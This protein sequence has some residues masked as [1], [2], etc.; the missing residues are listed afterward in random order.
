ML[1]NQDNLKE[2]TALNKTNGDT[3]IWNLK[4]NR[5]RAYISISLHSVSVFDLVIPLH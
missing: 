1:M 4:L 2:T 5:D 3:Y